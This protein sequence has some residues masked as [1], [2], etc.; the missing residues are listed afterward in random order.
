M[1]G[2]ISLYKPTTTLQPKV[3]GFV[4]CT[5]SHCLFPKAMDNQPEKYSKDTAV[6]RLVV[7]KSRRES[8]HAQ[9]FQFKIPTKRVRMCGFSSRLLDNQPENCCSLAM[10]L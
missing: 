5:L 1:G 6:F 7:Q 10:P 3:L 9:N 8:T 4:W 2:V